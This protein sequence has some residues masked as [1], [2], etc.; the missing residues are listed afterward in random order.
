MKRDLNHYHPKKVSGY[1]FQ[2]SSSLALPELAS[3]GSSDEVQLERCPKTPKLMEK[4]HPPHPR[5]VSAVWPHDLGE[6]MSDE[7]DFSVTM[8]TTHKQN[9]R[10]SVQLHKTTK[11]EKF[12]IQHLPRVDSTVNPFA[13]IS[14]DDS[15]SSMTMTPICNESRS[16]QVFDKYLS[17]DDNIPLPIDHIPLSIQ[18][19]TKRSVAQNCHQ[20][21]SQCFST[22]FY[23]PKKSRKDTVPKFRNENEIPRELLIPILF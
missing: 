22:P 21:K 1:N 3:E 4:R 7:D 17:N 8:A 14:S 10:D 2:Q 15:S 18:Q 16:S 23:L 5:R 9:H 12:R 13:I 19:E 11:H 20:E 6:I